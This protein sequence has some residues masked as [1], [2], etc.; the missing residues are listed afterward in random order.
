MLLRVASVFALLWS[1][2]VCAQ[3][4]N[5]RVTPTFHVS[6]VDK[7]DT[8][9]VGEP[10]VCRLR[11]TVTAGHFNEQLTVRAWGTFFADY[12]ASASTP[13]IF[14]PIDDTTLSDLLAGGGQ[15]WRAGELVVH[16]NQ[17]VADVFRDSKRTS[18]PKG[19]QATTLFYHDFGGAMQAGTFRTKIWYAVVV[20]PTPGEFMLLFARKPIDLTFQVKG[21]Q[22]LDLDTMNSVLEDWRNEN[23]IKLHR[24][25]PVADDKERD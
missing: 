2:V 17:P 19:T 8:Y 3:G 21:E 20:E 10:W 15:I 25:L 23:K 22:V 11:A 14:G 13:D 7:K 1:S 12:E 16:W 5:G 18:I 4:D 6:V 24:D 9:G